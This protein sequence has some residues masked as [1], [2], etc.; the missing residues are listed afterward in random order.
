GAQG[1][2]RAAGSEAPRSPGRP[3]P[4][5]SGSPTR[6]PS[7]ASPRPNPLLGGRSPSRS[8]APAA[9]PWPQDQLALARIEAAVSSAALARPLDGEDGTPR[10]PPSPTRRWG[11]A[12]RSPPPRPADVG[13]EGAAAAPAAKA[14]HRRP[15]GEGEG[16]APE[17]RSSQSSRGSGGASQGS[18]A[19]HGGRRRHGR[20]SQDGE[21]QGSAAAAAAP[22]F[23]PAAYLQT[24]FS[25]AQPAGAEKPPR[26][27]RKTAGAAAEAPDGK[28]KHRRT[29][30]G[31]A[32]EEA[33]ASARAEDA[34]P[35]AAA[36]ARALPLAPPADRATAAAV[37]AVPPPATPPPQVVGH[38]RLPEPDSED[39]P[40]RT[41][42]KA[43]L[44]AERAE[45]TFGSPGVDVGDSCHAVAVER[46]SAIMKLG[47]CLS[48]V[49]DK[50]YSPEKPSLKQV[51]SGRTA[52]LEATGGTFGDFC[53]KEFDASAAKPMPLVWARL[54]RCAD[55]G[56]RAGGAEEKDRE[57]SIEPGVTMVRIMDHPEQM[58]AI[59]QRHQLPWS[60]ETATST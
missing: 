38:R 16:R 60:R 10:T 23:P 8:P 49:D 43:P 24:L 5:L 4:L 59:C 42:M 9:A 35:R 17:P 13:P 33:E 51:A 15:R 18:A 53:K 1:S 28:K 41:R 27:S 52:A 40:Q 19:G 21:S 39:S 56:I 45:P 26:R 22:A 47:S 37:A 57:P 58:K 50:F 11:K 3:N 48:M 32:A 34:A 30:R 55:L 25:D 6:Q 12:S 2:G 29:A 36:A 44:R 14:K 31:G 20:P 46:Q 7:A 54:P